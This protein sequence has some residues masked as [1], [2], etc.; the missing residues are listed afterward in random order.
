MTLRDAL[1]Q[2]CNV[3]FL[4]AASYQ[5]NVFY[6]GLNSMWHFTSDF[7]TEYATDFQYAAAAI[8]EG[9]MVRV[10]PLAAARNYAA[11][12]EGTALLA[13]HPDERA[14]H[15]EYT[16]TISPATQSFILSA[17]SETVK[18]GTLKGLSSARG[19]RV[20]AGKTGTATQYRKKY[21]THGWA[22]V[23]FEY[24]N[25][26]YVLVVFV[27]KGTGPKDAKLFAGELLN[28]L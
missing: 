5:P 22:V 26:R 15:A 19:A 12:F 6:R 10:T 17:L 28:A 24:K 14:P 3:Y 25:I 2:S 4:T 18:T 7:E 1:I 21:M 9:G 13:P 20:I 27:E 23:Y 16:L 11:V 8:G